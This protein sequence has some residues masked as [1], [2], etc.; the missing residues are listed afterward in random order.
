MHWCSLCMCTPKQ[1]NRHMHQAQQSPIHLFPL[2]WLPE[3]LWMKSTSSGGPSRAKSKTYQKGWRRMEYHEALGTK[4]IQKARVELR[5]PLETS[6]LSK[7]CTLHA[8]YPCFQCRSSMIAWQYRVY[9]L[10]ARAFAQY[11]SHVFL[12]VLCRVRMG[13]HWML[14]MSMCIYIYTYMYIIYIY[15]YHQLSI[16]TLCVKY[17]CSLR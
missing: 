8:K 13:A 5:K 4:C 17:T 12:R 10:C 1:S 15:N 9:C 11:N 2:W 3:G 6:V 14:W 16:D 7:W